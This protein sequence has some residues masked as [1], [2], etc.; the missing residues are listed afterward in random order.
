[1]WNKRM[2]SQL[3]CTFGFLTAKCAPT[4][5]L[6]LATPTIPASRRPSFF[7]SQNLATL[8]ETEQRCLFALRQHQA[9]I[10]TKGRKRARFILQLSEQQAPQKHR[11]DVTFRSW[12]ERSSRHPAG[13]EQHF[14]DAAWTKKNRARDL[15]EKSEWCEAVNPVSA[16][17]VERPPDVSFVRLLRKTGIPAETRRPCD[18]RRS[19][20]QIK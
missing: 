19:R 12:V 10:K 6:G 2:A 7:L 15:S 5:C 8:F 14:I 3:Q 13:K 17:A 18:R 1:M 16:P 11:R 9:A 20:T 4:C